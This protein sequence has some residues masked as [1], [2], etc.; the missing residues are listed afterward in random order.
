MNQTHHD[1]PTPGA[2]DAH[3]LQGPTIDGLPYFDFGRRNLRLTSPFQR[4][5]DVKILQVLLKVADRF[6]PGPVDGIFGPRTDQAV[7]D[8]QSYYGLA[9]DGIVGPDTFWTLGQATG[10][11]LKGQPRFGSRPL[12]Q[13][14]SGGD[15]AVLQNRLN[16]AGQT[17]AGPATGSFDPATK[18]A[19]K[20]FQ[21]RYGLVPDGIVGPVTTYH[22]KL[23]TWLGGRHLSLGLKG[24]DVRQLQRWLNSINE[25]QVVAV[26][27]FFGGQTGNAVRTFQSFNTIPADGIVG[28]QT[29][30]VLGRYTN[31]IGLDSEGRIIYRHLDLT[32]G[33]YSI[34]SVKPDGSDPTNLTGAL[35]VVPG[36][37]L[38]SPDRVW[39]AYVADD[40]QLYI[41]PG[42]G[43]TP[44]AITTGVIAT[45]FSWS[46]DSNTLAVVKQSG[47]FLVN[48]AT[49]TATFLVGGGF[50]VF[51]PSGTRIAFAGGD[52]LVL[53]AINTDGTGLVTLDSET[54]PYHA[55][56]M[57]SDGTRIAYTTPGVSISF[58][59][60]FD[61]T[62]GR[63]LTVPAG[64]QGKD[65]CPAWSPN[66]KLLALSATDFRSGQGFFGI[67]RVADNFAKIVFD[68]AE[69]T[70]FSGCRITWG[71][72][73]DR[74][75]Y[76][77]ACGPDAGL[78]GTVFSVG[79][80]AS[81][82]VQ[83]VPGARNDAA[84]WTPVPAAT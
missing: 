18:A 36:G 7:R 16:I 19:V 42:T 13:G 71:P 10:P 75:A 48:R 84:D 79:L 62:T 82:P 52:N 3:S 72:N 73:S 32:T 63:R 26:D 81:I 12:Q 57:S 25:V 67:I 11:Y 58:V 76:A 22:L 28:P 64:P 41:V 78:T 65:Y 47:I 51:F 6:E 45:E 37:P 77:S 80:F 14:M 60:I 50:P 46:P 30:N 33:A 31:E 23:R 34:I 40:Q 68:I 38:W 9:V 61:V 66:G 4:G 5:T 27:G 44:Q 74:V 55:L 49:G 2:G 24:T 39:V 15:V 54:P 83:I 56:A 70:C 69:S 8:F 53:Q 21:A 59:I 1:D 20:A 43:G 29:F 35:A 17:R